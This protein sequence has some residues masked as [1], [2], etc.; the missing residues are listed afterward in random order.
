M[1]KKHSKDYWAGREAE[2]NFGGGHAGI[3]LAKTKVDAVGSLT[4]MEK[5]YKD[6][7]QL[8]PQVIDAYERVKEAGDDIWEGS[9]HRMGKV[10]LAGKTK[11]YIQSNA[12]FLKIMSAAAAGLMDSDV[13][14]WQTGLDDATPANDP[15]RFESFGVMPK[16]EYKIHWETGNGKDAP[17]APYHECDWTCYATTAD[18]GAGT[19]VLSFAKKDTL[20]IAGAPIQLWKDMGITI[21]GQTIRPKSV[22]VI[23][24]ITYDE[25]IE[26]GGE[27][28][29][30]PVIISM[31]FSVE[32]TFSE[33]PDVAG[34][35]D[36]VKNLYAGTLDTF[37]VVID[38]GVDTITTANCRLEDSN[39]DQ[40]L[41]AFGMKE[42]T[43]KIVQSTGFTI[44]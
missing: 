37:P 26:E 4:G 5:A 3:L 19:D 20:A 18:I 28:N 21:D 43:A 13:W 30:N 7:K 33:N 31:E 10:V 16:E 12:T 8:W 2:T 17:P 35:L 32:L 34:G 29:D 9:D 15:R 27:G 11:T 23:F 14:H 25:A 41:P 39:A 36:I 22:D 6:E 42:F 1:G 44:A 24:K 40:E 38:F